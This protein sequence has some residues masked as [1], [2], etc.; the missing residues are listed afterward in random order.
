MFDCH[1]KYI[2]VQKYDLEPIMTGCRQ[3]AEKTQASARSYLIGLALQLIG[4]GTK[5]DKTILASQ[6]EEFWPV[7]DEPNL[8]SKIIIGYESVTSSGYAV[9]KS[10]LQSVVHLMDVSVLAV[11]TFYELVIY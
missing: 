3:A 7:T 9:T 10:F 1:L 8:V 4:A 2:F 5:F 11:N 6:M